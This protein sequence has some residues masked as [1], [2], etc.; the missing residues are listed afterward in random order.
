MRTRK[1]TRNLLWLSI[2]L[3][4]LILL[5]LGVKVARNGI[6]GLSAW[7]LHVHLVPVSAINGEATFQLQPDYRFAVFYAAAILG[8]VA[9]TLFLVRLYLRGRNGKQVAG[10]SYPY[11]APHARGL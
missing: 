8:A 11:D 2:L 7:F 1:L 9:L 4:A 5:G 6:N 3:D 10:A